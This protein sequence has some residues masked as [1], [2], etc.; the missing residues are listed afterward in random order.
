VLLRRLTSVA[1]ITTVGALLTAS[2]ATGAVSSQE[3]AAAVEVRRL[4][5][6]D[7]YATAAA[8]ARATFPEGARNI[9]VARGDAFPDALSAVNLAAP[10][11]YETEARAG[12]PILLTPRSGLPAT[13]TAAIRQIPE[14]RPG[15]VQHSYVVG[16]SDVVSTTVERQLREAAPSAFL[17]RI[18]GSDRY[19]TNHQAYHA[20]FNGEAEIPREI[21][22]ART[23]FLVSGAS[24]ADGIS[25]GPLSYKERVPLLLTAPDRLLD[26]TRRS[27]IYLKSSPPP[28]NVIVVGGPAAVSDNVVRQV[29][30]LGMNVT[31]IAGSNRQETAIKLF[32]FAEKEFGWKLDHV[33][34]ARGDDFA[35]A[36]AGGPHAGQERAPILLTTG[37]D[38]L[39]ST[40]RDFLRS[41]AGTIT[42]I[43]VLGDRT[44]VSDAVVEQ[45][46]TAA[47][48]TP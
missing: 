43:D 41:R 36:L 31:R 39:S 25:A 37:V 10:R 8:I 30:A 22:G 3:Q 17:R 15:D 26:A 28:Q 23:Y 21:G 27:L 42:S 16:T 14:A 2:A 46:R 35:D 12:G 32:E 19:S 40:T 11:S 7:R 24:Y 13:T 48:T 1:S 6:A 44:A 18:G 4:A 33:N 20:S 45:A 9:V 5:G 47:A 29:R 38:D 34:L